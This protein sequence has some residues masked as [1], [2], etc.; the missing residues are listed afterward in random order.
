[1]SSVAHRSNE[2]KPWSDLFANFG[3]LSD[4]WGLVSVCLI[5]G[6]STGDEP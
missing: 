3:L 6:L 5:K 4:F 1:M 2:V